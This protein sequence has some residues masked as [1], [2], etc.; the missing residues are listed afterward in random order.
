MKGWY[1]FQNDLIT[2][3]KCHANFH[4]LWHRKIENTINV[5]SDDVKKYDN[6]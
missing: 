1:G 2:M 3:L 6:C 5:D 4:S